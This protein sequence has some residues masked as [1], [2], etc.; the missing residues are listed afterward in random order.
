[1]RDY[2]EVN[3]E[4]TPFSDVGEARSALLERAGL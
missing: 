1:M 4:R 2:Q 3:G